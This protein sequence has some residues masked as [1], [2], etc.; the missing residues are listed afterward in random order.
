MWSTTVNYKKYTHMVQIITPKGASN[1]T[2]WCKLH[3]PGSFKKREYNRKR[4]HVVDRFYCTKSGYDL[5]MSEFKDRVE[6]HS[7]PF[8]DVAEQQLLQGMTLELR[9][10]LYYNKYRYAVHLFVPDN[11]FN[12]KEWCAASLGTHKIDYHVVSSILYLRSADELMHI[13]LTF[14]EH[15]YSTKCAWLEDEVVS[16]I[17]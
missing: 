9:D 17:R 12:L 11:N 8:N 5:L 16:A 6:E 3:L 4:T 1:P 13:K 2:D 14:G 10:H 15:I 7:K